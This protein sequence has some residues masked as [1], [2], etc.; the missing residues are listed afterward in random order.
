M[1]QFFT[2]ILIISL[3]GLIM[4]GYYA[5]KGYS[6]RHK[7]NKLK[8]RLSNKYYDDEKTFIRNY[9]RFLL[10]QL[11]R[12]EIQWIMVSSRR[13]PWEKIE[14]TYSVINQHIELK[15]RGERLNTPQ[16]SELKQLGLKS[17]TAQEDVQVLTSS[18]NPKIVTDLIYYLLEI[19][20][21]QKKALNIKVITS[22]GYF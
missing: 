18:V 22:G 4:V 16:Q 7:D 9:F 2:A 3:A 12:G 19:V 1:K 5:L 10:A 6:K 15:D 14:V 17:Y 8:Q 11:K 20:H 21:N 13:Y